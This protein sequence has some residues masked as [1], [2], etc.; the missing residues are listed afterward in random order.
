MNDILTG[1]ILLI[2]VT[3]LSLNIFI[4][5]NGI[6]SI[7]F[8][9]MSTLEYVSYTL[10]SRGKPEL[11]SL[12]VRLCIIGITGCYAF[13]Y[14]SILYHTLMVRRIDVKI[15]KNREELDELTSQIDELSKQ[16]EML[17]EG[18]AKAREE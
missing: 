7:I 18:M 14:V 1:A 16:A 10:I 2:L 11:Q 12:F 15:D 4:F 9:R 17:R 13:M 6:I 5:V 3:L 8:D